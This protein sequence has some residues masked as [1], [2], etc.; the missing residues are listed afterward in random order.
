MSHKERQLKTNL[1]KYVADLNQKISDVENPEDRQIHEAMVVLA[2]ALAIGPHV[3]RLVQ[4]T[5][6]GEQFVVEI[7]GRMREAGLWSEDSVDDRELRDS[8]GDVLGPVLFVHAM[9]ALGHVKR[10][11]VTLTGAV[12]IDVKTGEVVRPLEWVSPDAGH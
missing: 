11:V 6:Y 5:G 4:E 3:D 1:R 9:I 8:N 10:Q 7:S 12:Y 2:S